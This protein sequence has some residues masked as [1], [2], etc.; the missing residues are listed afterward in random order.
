VQAVAARRGALRVVVST[1]GR[2]EPIEDVEIRARFDGRVVFIPDAGKQVAA[3]EV[4]VRF[5]ETPVTAAVAQAESERLASLEALRAARDTLA[6]VRNRTATDTTLFRQGAL[7][8]EAYEAGQ[9]ELRAAQA[10]LAN[11]ERETPLR[12]AA[13]ELQIKDLRA[14]QEAAVVRA[15]FAGTIYKTEVKQGAVVRS[16]DLLLSLADLQRLRLR[17]NVDQVDLGRVRVGQRVLVSAN[18]FPGRQWSGTL[19][20][21][22]PNVIVKESRAVAEAL[23]AIDPP[24]DGL[25]PG[26]TVDV[27][28]VVAEKA[29]ALQVPADAVF[30]L[31]GESFVYRVDE[32]RARRAQVT[33]GLSSIDAIEITGGL[34]EGTRVVVGATPGLEDGARVQ[35][36]GD[37]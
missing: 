21:I 34:E 4:I 24:H 28:I 20:E 13:L 2:I 30:T 6:Q 16:G 23:A 12:V 7:A 25:V 18:A 5:D 35:V 27:E 26:M 9:A 15:P 29:G 3:G 10:R 33:T 14:Q 8:R 19:D 37:A 1:N 31:G 22:V 32:R 36:E 17:A 11:Q